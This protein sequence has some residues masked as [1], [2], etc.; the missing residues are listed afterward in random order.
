MNTVPQAAD[1]VLPAI[2]A[3]LVVLGLILA[4]AWMAKRW[5]R[6]PGLSRSGFNVLGALS[7]GP[8]E[9]LLLVEIGGQQVLLGVTPGSVTSLQTLARPIDLSVPASGTDGDDVTE[10]SARSPFAAALAR[11][12]NE[13]RGRKAGGVHRG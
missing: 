5:L 4:L 11:A 8:R 9:K 6:A 10:R 3:L 13:L 7:I 1:Q 2:G 12:G